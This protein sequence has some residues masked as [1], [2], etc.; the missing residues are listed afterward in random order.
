VDTSGCLSFRPAGTGVGRARSEKDEQQDH[1]D[2]D[3]G[4]DCNGACVHVNSFG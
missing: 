2:E 3:E 4:D 1:D